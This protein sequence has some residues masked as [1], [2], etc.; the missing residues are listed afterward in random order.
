MYICLVC[1][2]AYMFRSDVNWPAAE[3]KL[4]ICTQLCHRS[5]NSQSAVCR[6]QVATHRSQFCSQY[7]YHALLRAA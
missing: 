7:N 6:E 4:Q 2:Y 5:K 1:I 3:V